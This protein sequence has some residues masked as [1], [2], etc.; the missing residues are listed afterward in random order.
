MSKSPRMMT[1]VVTM[2][3]E[4]RSF[5]KMLFSSRMLLLKPGKKPYLIDLLFTVRL[6]DI[7]QQNKVYRESYMLC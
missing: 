6:K 3:L 5:S 4:Y 2:T 1:G 7:N